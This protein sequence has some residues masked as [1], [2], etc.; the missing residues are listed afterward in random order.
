MEMGMTEQ[1]LPKVS[2]ITPSKDQAI[3]LER[4]IRSVLSQDYPNIEYIIIDGGS[5]DGSREIIEKYADRGVLAVQKTKGR[6]TPLTVVSRGQAGDFGMAEF[7]RRPVS[8]CGQRGGVL[9][10]EAP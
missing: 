2:I 9:P 10:A 1:N 8:R 5:T 7:G 6:P 3:F 4:T